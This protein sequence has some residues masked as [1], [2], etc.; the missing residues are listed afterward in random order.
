VL[1]LQF[2]TAPHLPQPIQSTNSTNK[3]TSAARA[4]PTSFPPLSG[5]VLCSAT[6]QLLSCSP[7]SQLTA[8]P[9]RINHPNHPTNPNHRAPW[10][11]P[12]R[13]HLTQFPHITAAAH[14]TNS[15]PNHQFKTTVSYLNLTHHHSKPNQHRAL[16]LTKFS[17][18]SR[19]QNPKPNQV[20]HHQFQKQ[21]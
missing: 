15:K 1:F 3:S 6:L 12:N 13:P 4:P 5:P 9:A 8:T 19:P 16:M 18:P 2:T 14:Q 21:T 11:N 20:H 17:Q 10:Q 7:N